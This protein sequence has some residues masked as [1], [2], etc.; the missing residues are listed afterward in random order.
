MRGQMHEDCRRRPLAFIDG[1][2]EQLTSI[3]YWRDSSFEEGAWLWQAIFF[4]E[5]FLAIRFQ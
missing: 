1:S 5:G 4:L 2:L 3:I